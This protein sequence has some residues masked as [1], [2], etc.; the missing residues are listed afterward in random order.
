MPNLLRMPTLLFGKK[1]FLHAI[2]C[3]LP[4]IDVQQIIATK[5]NRNENKLWS[6]ILLQYPPLYPHWTPKVSKETSGLPVRELSKAHCPSRSNTG[7]SPFPSIWIIH[8]HNPE[9]HGVSVSRSPSSAHAVKSIHGPSHTPSQKP[10]WGCLTF[11]SE[12]KD[13]FCQQKELEWRRPSV[14]LKFK[15]GDFTI[16]TFWGRSASQAHRS[17]TG[18]DRSRH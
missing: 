1:L 5:D 15:D 13:I 12:S 6:E 8:F 2:G 4:R 3:A 7:K 9:Q 11:P 16:M 17:R 14:T 10:L 18:L